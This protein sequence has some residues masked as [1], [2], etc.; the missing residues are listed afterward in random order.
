MNLT[1]YIN[2]SWPSIQIGDQISKVYKKL[3]KHESL[4]LCDGRSYLGVITLD[5]F[6]Q[7]TKDDQNEFGFTDAR[8]FRPMVSVHQSPIEATRTL[9]S[10]PLDFLPIVDAEGQYLG[11][12]DLDSI[13]DYYL[14]TEA[15][16]SDG[17]VITLEV[18][19]RNYSL[20]EIAQICESSDKRVLG[21][22][23]HTNDH[24]DTLLVTMHL[25]EQNISDLIA[26]LERYGY[27]IVNTLGY[28]DNQ[29]KLKENYDVL[30]SYLEL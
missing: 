24:N 21:M 20:S 3:E 1:K 18:E 10:I 9:Q 29:D 22:D 28:Q 5:E 30:M 11:V 17:A 15:M 27:N 13:R 12:W 4:P 23:I 25:D 19:P 7:I 2:T 8:L 14:D 16:R 26:A 6:D